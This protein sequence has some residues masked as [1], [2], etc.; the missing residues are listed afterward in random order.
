MNPY[1]IIHSILVT[2]KGTELAEDFNQYTFKVARDAAKPH[3]RRAVEEIFDVEVEA[4][5]V[6]NRLGKKKRG[7]YGTYGKRADWRK[8]V[9]TL[10]E[11]S[12]IDLI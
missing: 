7:R 10:K 11:G 4:V 2:E 3:I 9:V 12:S 5:N 6:M 1:R 8:A